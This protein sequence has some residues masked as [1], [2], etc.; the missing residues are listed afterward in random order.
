MS[1]QAS[2]T[3]W[4]ISRRTRRED[5]ETTKAELTSEPGSGRGAGGAGGAGDTHWAP[6]AG[7]AG[8][9]AEG[10][11]AKA[12]GARRAPHRRAAAKGQPGAPG[13]FGAAFEGREGA[14]SGPRPNA[15]GRGGAPSPRSA[16]GDG[17]RLPVP[18]Q[19]SS[20]PG[21]RFRNLYQNVSTR[22]GSAP[23]CAASSGASSTSPSHRPGSCSA[24]AP[25]PAAVPAGLRRTAPRGSQP[26]SSGREPTTS[27]SGPRPATA[28]GTTTPNRN[29]MAAGGAAA[30]PVS[31][32]PADVARARGGRGDWAAARGAWS[33]GAGAPAG[34]R[35]R[36]HLFWAASRGPGAG[37]CSSPACGGGRSG[38]R[39]GR[40]LALA[41]RLVLQRGSAGRRREG[42]G[43]QPGLGNVSEAPRVSSR[44]SPGH[45][46][47]FV[48]V[49]KNK[50]VA[51]SEVR[52]RSRTRYLE[53]SGP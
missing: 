30:V 53:S 1:E 6:G 33:P 12:K 5:T 49:V 47:I 40:T 22:P 27:S 10:R 29:R 39:R 52:G 45:K 42:R 2:S 44:L 32:R 21:S 14:R 20:P 43:G 24:S 17:R 11:G 3:G 50:G 41:G 8:K 28:G 46:I 19:E 34:T 15:P 26:P 25:A 31:P 48:R 7:C 51:G 35:A 18:S 23:S 36:M 16:P 13:E 38:L 4:V 9:R 37:A